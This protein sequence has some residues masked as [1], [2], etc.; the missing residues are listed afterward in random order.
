MDKVICTH[1]LTGKCGYG[2]NCKKIHPVDKK[3]AILEYNA[4]GT[5]EICQR[6]Y[7]HNQADCEFIHIKTTNTNIEKLVIEQVMSHI[8]K[9]YSYHLIKYT[10]SNNELEYKKLAAIK[11]KLE[12]ISHELS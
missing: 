11:A 3:Q 12:A 4:K 7:L 10:D 6:E 9:A 8:L 2:E 1:Y 5:V